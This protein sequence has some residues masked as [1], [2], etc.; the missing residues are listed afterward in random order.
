MARHGHLLLL[1]STGGKV[2]HVGHQVAML[3]TSQGGITAMAPLTA[4]MYGITTNKVANAAQPG[5]TCSTLTI[6]CW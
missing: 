1:A 5:G 6:L 2:K 3:S 4:I